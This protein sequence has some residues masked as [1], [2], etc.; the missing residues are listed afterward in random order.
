VTFQVLRLVAPPSNFEEA[1]TLLSLG[2]CVS[3]RHQWP[4][5]PRR[6]PANV[7]LGHAGGRLFI[8]AYL[9]DRSIWSTASAH[10]QRLWEQGDTFEMFFQ[11]EDR[12]EYCELHV[13][14]AN[15]RLQLRFPSPEVFAAKRDTAFEEFLLEEGAFTSETAIRDRDWV[16]FASIPAKLIGAKGKRWRFSFCRYDYDAGTVEPVLSST[17][18]YRELDFHRIE[19]W[20]T[21]EFE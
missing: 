19:D 5:D 21:L 3:L 1:L 16:V 20:G 8:L 2:D 13:T 17:S 9:P 18:R 6:L 4:A 15:Y 12:E 11:A 10:N 7:W 14:P